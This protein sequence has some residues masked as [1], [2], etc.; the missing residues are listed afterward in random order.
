MKP[1]AKIA[2]IQKDNTNSLLKVDRV[3]LVIDY[4]AGSTGG[5]SLL[6]VA[7]QS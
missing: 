6:L 3:A 1:P 4:R 5:G 7:P 2:N